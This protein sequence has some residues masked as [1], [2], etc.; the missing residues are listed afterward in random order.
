[1]NDCLLIIDPQ[2]DFT[3]LNGFYASQHDISQIIVAKKCINELLRVIEDGISVIIVYS[4]Y[5][6][7]QFGENMSMCI[8]GTEGHEMDI[9]KN[10]NHAHFSKNEHSAFSS[11]ELRKY[12]ENNKVKKIYMAGFLAEYCVK[13]TAVEALQSGYD[14]TI[15][16]DC[17]GTGDDRQ[18]QARLA[19]QE[20][21][22]SGGNIAD[23]R[24]CFR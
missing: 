16:R 1:M 2:K 9:D 7:N 11:S 24:S 13:A 19:Y 12:L 5:H 21:I 6:R 4:D 18:N 14:V 20:I 10:D 3:A 23:F 22:C 17:I 15:L 8:P